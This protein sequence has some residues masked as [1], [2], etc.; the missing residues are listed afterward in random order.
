MSQHI[1]IWF[2]P[3]GDFLEVVFYD[4]PGYMQETN[5]DAVMERVDEDG[6]LLGFSILGVSQLDK[7][8]PLIAE[9]TAKAS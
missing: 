7:A 4:R 6:N 9:L 3:E 8:T 2:D 5:N 1:K